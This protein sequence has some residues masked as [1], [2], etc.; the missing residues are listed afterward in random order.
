[1]QELLRRG[2]VKAEPQGAR[3]LGRQRDSGCRGGI[4]VERAIEVGPSGTR[5]RRPTESVLRF[6]GGCVRGL[7]WVDVRQSRADASVQLGGN[8]VDFRRRSWA[9]RDGFCPGASGSTDLGYPKP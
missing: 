4:S 2:H 1:M 7:G 8:V 3:R 6:A 5:G 9:D